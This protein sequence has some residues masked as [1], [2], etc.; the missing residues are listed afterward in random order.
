MAH[1]MAH[2]DDFIGAGVKATATAIPAG[3][4]QVPTLVFLLLYY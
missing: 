4:S 2:S 3:H 1:H